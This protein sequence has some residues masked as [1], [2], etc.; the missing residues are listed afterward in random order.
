M[1]TAAAAKLFEGGPFDLSQVLEMEK[2][3]TVHSFP[4]KTRLRFRGQS[5]EREFS[6]SNVAGL[7]PGRHFGSN[8][9][10]ILISAHYDHLGVGPD[11]KGDS[12]YNGV[13]DNAVGVAAVLK[14][15]DAIGYGGLA[16]GANVIHCKINRIEPSE[17]NVT[18]TQYPI[19]R[20]LYFYTIDTPRGNIK[21]FIDWVLGDGQKIVREVGYIPLWNE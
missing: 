16:Y 12:I 10:Y 6:A 14:D 4:L 7:L 15:P 3:L 20:Y 9:F 18:N 8:D 19:I 5:L 13:M 21:A 11:V 2:T 1:N 17:Q